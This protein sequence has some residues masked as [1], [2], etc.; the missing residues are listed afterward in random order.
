MEKCP[1]Y[2]PRILKCAIIRTVK[3]LSKVETEN[4]DSSDDGDDDD[5]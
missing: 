2:Q 4:V 3:R 1:K 5:N